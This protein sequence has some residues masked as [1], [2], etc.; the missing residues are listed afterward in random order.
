[1]NMTPSC[2]TMYVPIP[3]MDDLGSFALLFQYNTK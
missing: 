1:M 3:H 2:V